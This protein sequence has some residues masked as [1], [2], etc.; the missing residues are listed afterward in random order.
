M[1]DIVQ[2]FPNLV[3]ILRGMI[4]ALTWFVVHN[5]RYWSV[6]VTLY[7]IY[8]FLHVVTLMSPSELPKGVRYSLILEMVVDRTL[9]ATTYFILGKV[10]PQHFFKFVVCFVIDFFSNWVDYMTSFAMDLRLKD[11]ATGL[12]SFLCD[13]PFVRGA[14][15]WATKFALLALYLTHLF[16]DKAEHTRSVKIVAHIAMGTIGLQLFA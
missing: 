11:D 10:F 15:V 13:R 5:D 7:A 3:R 16:I 8:L 4:V 14:I 2:D 12:T 1:E 6:F 9:V